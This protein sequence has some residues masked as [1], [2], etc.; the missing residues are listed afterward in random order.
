[1]LARGLFLLHARHG[2]LPMEPLIT[3][4]EQLA[5]FGVPASQ[6]L[7]RDL[8]LVA[9]P[10]F[11]DPA[12]RAVFSRD[13]VPLTEGQTLVQPDLAATLAQLR[14]DGVGDFY[15]GIFARR[16][17]QA[18]PAAGVP[19]GLADLRAALPSLAVP[20]AVPLWRRSG[21][22]SADRWRCGGGGGVHDVKEPAGGR[23]GR[24]W[25]FARGGGTLARGWG[26]FRSGPE[27]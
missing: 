17:E 19:I 10:L 11:A 14:I 15:Q 20:V 27:W 23:S 16:L 1:M 25:A 5:R 9:G 4:A 22:I 2:A 24:F 7:V 12:A 18:S 21:R 8:V 13:G 6:A 3:K 26:E